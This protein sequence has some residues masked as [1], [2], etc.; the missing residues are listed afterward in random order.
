MKKKE[1]KKKKKSDEENPLEIRKK[2]LLSV[3][4]LGFLLA[5]SND[6]NSHQW[7]LKTNI[8]FNCVATTVPFT[9]ITAQTTCGNSIDENFFY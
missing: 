9:C 7:F 5:T 8:I 3:E 2:F 1:K 4:A 6:D